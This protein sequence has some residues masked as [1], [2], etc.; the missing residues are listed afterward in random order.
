MPKPPPAD[1]SWL[2]TGEQA[3]AARRQKPPRAAKA[4]REGW[5]MIAIGLA[6][7]TA[8]WG[9]GLIWPWLAPFLAPAWSLGMAGFL[10]GMKTLGWAQGYATGHADARDRA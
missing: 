4:R 10:A 1:Q 7:A 2:K 9:A 6:L 3:A 5:L 8:E